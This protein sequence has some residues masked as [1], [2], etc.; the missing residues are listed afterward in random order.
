MNMSK[1][2]YV[3]Q[4]L[5]SFGEFVELNEWNKDFTSE[6]DYYSSTYY[7]GNDGVAY[8]KKNG[9]IK[10]FK[11]VKT[12]SIWFDFDHESNLEL[13]KNDVKVLIARLKNAGIDE[14][15]I[16]IYFSGSKGFTVQF[17][18]NK[19][20]NR[21]QV[22]HLA[23]DVFGQ[24]LETLDTTMYDESQIFRVPNTKHPKTGLYK[25]QLSLEQLELSIDDIK[26]YAKTTKPLKDKEIS[27]LKEELLKIPEKPKPASNVALNFDLSK[28]PLHWKDYKWALLN[29]H[30][31]KEN[32]RHSALMV[33]AATCKGLGYDQTLTQAMCLTFDEK[34]Q[35]L[36]GKP[37]VEDL[38][39]V[40]ES[41]FADDWNGG[42]YSFKNNKW[43]QEYCN[44]VG[45]NTKDANDEIVGI[46]DIKDEFVHFVDHIDENTILTGINKLD[47]EVPITVGM[48]LGIVGA[49][50]SGKTALALEILKNTSKKGVISV[51]VSLDMHRKR[52]F[53]KLLYKVS[54]FPREELYKKVRNREMD[55]IYE[56]VK[57][58]YGNVWFFDRSSATVE[59]VREYI[60]EVEEKTGQKVKLVMIDYFERV[61]SERSDE[62]AASKDIAGKLQDLV[63]DLDI[64]MITLVQPNKFSLAS[65]PDQP[66]TNYTAIKGSS[67][68][69]QS[70]RAIISIWRPFFTPETKN[71]DKYLQMGILK[72]DLGELGILDFKWNGKRG[73]ITEF[74]SDEDREHF[75]DLLAEKQRKKDGKKDDDSW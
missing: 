75:N 27:N 25:V 30:M 55:S 8:F 69:Y 4:G 43:L 22:E 65:G 14:S 58:D 47:K 9:K 60:K 38:D 61:N 67:F 12:E 68:L 23:I 72:N 42:Q 44:R 7:Y 5:N 2:I 20:L 52:L 63:N 39:N 62:T 49:A 71:E 36:T 16:D 31:L 24:G 66:I 51:F 45:V 57:E 15:A 11:N 21:T 64:A 53:E 56:K 37:A 10:G 34:F 54:G 18:T 26:K 50:S 6:D 35:K 33:I 59:N 73:E 29:A 41:I 28:R 40:I 13:A 74:A 3:K 70:F 32:E 48:N 1:F 19:T 46:Y 17:R